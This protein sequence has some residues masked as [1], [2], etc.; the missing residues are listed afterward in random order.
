MKRRFLI[1]R[2]ALLAAG[3]LALG[4]H[5]RGDT[6]V[7]TTNFSEEIVIAT[8]TYES[9]SGNVLF[10]VSGVGYSDSLSPNIAADLAADSELPTQI[11]STA[12]LIPQVSEYQFLTG[13][14][15]SYFVPNDLGPAIKASTNNNN[16]QDLTPAGPYTFLYAAGGPGFAFTGDE[17]ATAIRAESYSTGTVGPD[18]SIYQ[19]TVTFAFLAVNIIEKPVAATPAALPSKNRLLENVCI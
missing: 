11:S 13:Q 10:T 15:P 2:S 18:G 12:L 14:G 16:V 9:A 17:Y 19:G 7:H 8:D 4:S 3:T 6:I 5:A 1:C